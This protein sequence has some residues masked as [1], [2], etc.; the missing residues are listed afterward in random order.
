MTGN[1]VHQSCEAATFDNHAT[2]HDIPADGHTKGRKHF[3][4][5]E[6]IAEQNVLAVLTI[7]PTI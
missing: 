3:F 5:S 7:F 6:A 1:S 2:S 4:W